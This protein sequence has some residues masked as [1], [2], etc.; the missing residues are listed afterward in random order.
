MRRLLRNKQ[1]IYYKEK[2][3]CNVKK[4]NSS[5]SIIIIVRQ[6]KNRPPEKKKFVRMWDV[7][8]F[9]FLNPIHRLAY[10]KSCVKTCPLS[11]CGV[12]SIPLLHNSLHCTIL[13]LLPPPLSPLPIPFFDSLPTMPY[14]RNY[15][16]L[17]GVVNATA[18][19]VLGPY[20]ATA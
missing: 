14:T 2:K 17:N 15:A 16:A 10:Y 3:R 19:N 13:A 12:E 5:T 7:Y 11:H 1:L 6:Y 20:V 18:Q 4:G 8:E 9:F